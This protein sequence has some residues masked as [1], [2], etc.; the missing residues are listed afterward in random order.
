MNPIIRLCK[1]TM[2]EGKMEVVEKMTS[3]LGIELKASDKELRGKDLMKCVFMKWIDAAET[4]L[5]MIIMKLPSP[6][7]A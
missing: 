2:D 3:K 6:I 7:V 5:D 4:L 1:A